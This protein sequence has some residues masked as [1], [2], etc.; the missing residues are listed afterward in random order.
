MRKCKN[1]HTHTFL[2]HIW[3]KSYFS[4]FCFSGFWNFETVKSSCKR[5]CHYFAENAHRSHFRCAWSCNLKI[6]DTLQHITGKVKG[7]F[8]FAESENFFNEHQNTIFSRLADHLKNK[9]HK[10][11]FFCRNH[12]MNRFNVEK[13]IGD[14]LLTFV[15][16]RDLLEVWYQNGIELFS[17]KIFFYIQQKFCTPV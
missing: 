4:G 2:H 1:R 12:S 11:N 17:K 8:F 9:N 3:F 5:R 7:N 16:L 15:W 6:G 10:K 13:L 14:V